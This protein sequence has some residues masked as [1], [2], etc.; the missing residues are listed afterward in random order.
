MLLFLQYREN[1]YVK[2][3]QPLQIE[4][5]P[6]VLRIIL[7]TQLKVQLLFFLFHKMFDIVVYTSLDSLN[8]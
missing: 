6:A 5:D 3:V 1:I 8:M 7:P 4:N 2:T